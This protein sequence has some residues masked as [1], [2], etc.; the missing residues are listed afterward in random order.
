MDTVFNTIVSMP[1]LLI[2]G[3]VALIMLGM[4]FVGEKLWRVRALRGVLIVLEGYKQV[5][6]PLIGFGLAWIPWIPLPETIAD[7]HR[8]FF[9]FIGLV[10]GALWREI[11]M[12]YKSRLKAKGLDVELELPP[13]QQR[14]LKKS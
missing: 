12:L 10:A 1:V 13:K 14:E 7:Y 2:G 6:P 8:G 9:A 3:L 4:N 11:F 5:F